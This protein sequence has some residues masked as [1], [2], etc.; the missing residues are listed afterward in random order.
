MERGI[1]SWCTCINLN[2]NTV[3]SNHK[4]SFL[5]EKKS[6]KEPARYVYFVGVD[7]YWFSFQQLIC[8]VYL[9]L[10]VNYVLDHN[11]V[12]P[13]HLLGRIFQV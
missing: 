13:K 4:V 3:R 7:L 5:S 2:K 9:Y 10:H 12:G 8:S 1:R 11:V 6:W